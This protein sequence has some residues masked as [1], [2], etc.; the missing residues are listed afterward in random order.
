MPVR[1]LED[2]V[3]YL[4]RRYIAAGAEGVFKESETLSGESGLL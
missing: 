4:G 3:L 1:I 2:E